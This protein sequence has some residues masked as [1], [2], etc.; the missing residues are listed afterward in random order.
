MK[1]LPAIS[2][3]NKI[4]VNPECWD[5][6]LN[7]AGFKVSVFMS[8]LLLF[9]PLGHWQLLFLF[10]NVVVFASVQFLVK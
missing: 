10:E 8:Y 4:K 2:N 7:I 5:V 3:K 1:R 6:L 9:C